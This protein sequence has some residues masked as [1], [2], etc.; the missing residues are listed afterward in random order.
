MYNRMTCIAACRCPLC[1]LI[2]LLPY[3]A[4]NDIG[5]PAASARAMFRPFCRMYA[6]D[7]MPSSD[8]K[9]ST[10]TRDS[11]RLRSPAI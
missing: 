3:L 8:V 10:E 5:R 7:I 4:Q 1:I 9:M 11:S 2:S 6:L